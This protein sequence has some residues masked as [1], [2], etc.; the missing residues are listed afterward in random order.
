MNDNDSAGDNVLVIDVSYLVYSVEHI[1]LTPS[2]PTLPLT[3][4][5]D[6]SPS[7]CLA[8]PTGS[9]TPPCLPTSP[10]SLTSPDSPASPGSPTSP[11]LPS[12]PISIEN[13]TFS[14]GLALANH[15]L[16][17]SLNPS[18]IQQYAGAYKR[19]KTFCSQNGFPEYPAAPEHVASCLSLVASETQSVSAVERLSAAISFE[20]RKHFL[21][22]PTLHATCLLLMRAVRKRYGG[23]RHAKEPLTSDLLCRVIDQLFQLKHGRNGLQAPLVLWRTVWRISMEYH[24]LGRFSDIVNLK[25]SSITIKEGPTPYM[26]VRFKGGKTDIFSEGC[27]RIVSSNPTHPI[28]CPVR[29]TRLYFY[30]LGEGFSGYLVPRLL[31][32]SVKLAQLPD[33]NRQL[34]YTTA[35]EDLRALLSS[36][37]L[38]ARLFGEHSGK[39]G[40]ATSAAAAGMDQP[41][42]QRLGG[43][44]SSQMAAKYTDLNLETRLKMSSLL[45]K[46]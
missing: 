7:L 22:S 40:G 11:G 15:L 37:G 8:L 36:L 45:Q 14:Q 38:D 29:L 5:P 1:C 2:S 32:G 28:Y 24:T 42:L 25:T 21:P 43:W 16:D 6:H 46:K 3:N 30:R 39:R 34:S 17:S 13:S 23:E 18:T 20:H 10:D 27:E 12:P 31:G 35:L 44:K 4:L 19:W 41:T 9:P 33:P 26:I